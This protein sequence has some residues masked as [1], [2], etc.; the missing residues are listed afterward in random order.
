MEIVGS[1][2][3]TLPEPSVEIT[4]RSHARFLF[5]SESSSRTRSCENNKITKK[6]WNSMI[7]LQLNKIL[8]YCNLMSYFTRIIPKLPYIVKYCLILTNIVIWANIVF[9]FMILS[10]SVRMFLLIP[11]IFKYFQIGQ[12]IVGYCQAQPSPN[13]T[14]QG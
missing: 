13:S 2:G 1:T 7:L 10:E 12:H 8:W 14:Q 3:S 4:L 9:Y 11:D 5:R 6:F